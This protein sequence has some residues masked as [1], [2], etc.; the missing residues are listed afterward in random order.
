MNKKHNFR[1]DP[2]Y[3]VIDE[4]EELRVVEGNFKPLF[5]RLKRINNLG[6]IPEVFEM[7]RYPK[8][9][10]GVGTLHQIN[11][12]L[13]VIDKKTIPNK[14]RKPLI[15]ASLFLHLGH[16]P[17]TYSTERAL[18]LASNLGDRGKENEIK[19]YVK[20]K[21]EK[22]LNRTG[23]RNERKKNILDNIFSLRDYK[24]LYRFFSA[25]ILVEKWADLK[26]KINGLSEKDLKVIIRDLI[27]K[28]YDGYVYLNLAD[29]AD[30]VQRDALYFGTVRIDV[31]P[32]HLYS[33]ISMYNP[34][35][36]VSEE[37]LIEYNF[38]YLTERFYDNPTIICFSRLYEKIVASLIISK[39][40]KLEWIEKYDDAQF[41]RLIC[42]GIDSNNKQIRLP[43]TW[44]NRAKE[45]FDKKITFSLIFDLKGVSFQKEKDVIDIEYELIG[46]RE[47]ERG[48]L[49]YPF[50]TGVLLAIDYLDKVDYP[51]H[52]NYHAFSIKVFQNK[53]NKSL[54]KLLKIIKNLSPYLS[55]R[56]VDTIRRGLANQISWTKEVRFSNEAVIRAISEA[57]QSI[58]SGKY[59]KGDFIGKYLKNLSDISTYGEL[60][61]NLDQFIWRGL[62][63]N[64]L[65]QHR[66]ELETWKIYK[67]FT[68]GLLS[69]PVRL[70]Q[71]KSTKRYLDEIYDKLLE[72][73][74]S[75]VSDDK[76][77]DLFEALWLINRLRTKK[78]KFQFFLS[79]M[80]VVDPN[81]P[82]NTRDQ[83]EFDIIE[84]SINDTGKAECWVYACSIADDYEAENLK[85]LTKLT[86]H[87]RKVF[88]DLI[89]RAR[90]VIPNNKNAGD[91][92]P[93]EENAGRDSN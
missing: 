58:E 7:A 25:E 8:Y 36:S 30:F 34:S 85:Q 78:G 73:I 18:L 82:R 3:R 62:I 5:D 38:N 56:H 67:L 31:S 76:R 83:N 12:L 87:M 49:T 44:L 47:S 88:P 57:I 21:I 6:I 74:S 53:S 50:D 68:R 63:N 20:R 72:K 16:F 81:R 46:K 43:S 22:V 35:Y 45:L 19:K 27:D 32:K 11:S 84:L 42:D 9:E 24:L 26:D 23:L 13:R 28:E 70:L 10:H 80:V 52:P 2:L 17:Y 75:D 37:K 71:Y 91:W 65:K 29:R 61:H 79:G 89:I 1:Y 93:R 15:L 92:A 64:F 40:F 66:K 69:L 33:G 54:D 48:L 14:Y 59:N 4:I 77:G 90:Y 41:K 51:V 86:D 60:W 55:F 39:N